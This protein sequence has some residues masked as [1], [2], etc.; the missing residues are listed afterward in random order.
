MFIYRA[1]KTN[2]LTQGF[3]DNK[4]PIYKEMGMRWHGGYDWVTH[5]DE[6][7]YFDCSARGTVLNTEIDR[8]GGLGVNIITESKEGIFKHRYWHLKDFAVKA[9]DVLETADLIGVSDNT[10]L[11]TGNHLHR[12][13]KEM[14]KDQYG[15]Y[16]IKDRDNGSYGTVSM[17]LVFK[18][19]FVKDHMETLKRKVTILEQQKISLIQ[20]IIATI[21][22]K[23][24]SLMSRLGIK[25]P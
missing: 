8:A 12:D 19:I 25:K 17:D 21:S 10:G 1:I 23:I 15:S 24:L 11:S 3:Y 13:R 14:I 9:G 4:S 5:P 22:L 7:V 16:K 2:L 20:L 6:K 18:N